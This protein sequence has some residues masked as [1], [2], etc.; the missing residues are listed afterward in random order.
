MFDTVFKDTVV[1]KEAQ[2]R[3]TPIC[4]TL[5]GTWL[6]SFSTSPPLL[7]LLS[8]SRLMVVLYPLR[9]KFK[10]KAYVAKI[11]VII[12]ITFCFVALPPTLIA[13]FIQS[14]LPSMICHPLI[15][16]CRNNVLTKVIVFIIGFHQVAA[17]VVIT[18][19]HVAL[20]K[21]LEKSDKNVSQCKSRQKSN[22]GLKVQL[23]FLSLSCAI[24]WIPSNTIF[25]VSNFL[26]QF[27]KEMVIW[28]SVCVSS[29]GPLLN[30]VLF[31][32]LSVKRL[33]QPEQDDKQVQNQAVSPDVQKVVRLSM[34]QARRIQTQIET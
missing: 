30:S 28:N 33:L 24:S 16:Y 26:H 31:L 17:C 1:V 34:P 12:L 5:Y 4:H 9:S 11:V 22:T 8:L 10:Q 32:V 2:W 25:I 27:P 18:V 29:L 21:K 13:Y 6:I 3:K 20:V 19:C 14:G 7:F 15:D 23:F